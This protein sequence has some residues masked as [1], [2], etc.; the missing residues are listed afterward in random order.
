MRRE[1]TGNWRA[2]RRRVSGRGFRYHPQVGRA[3]E[4]RLRGRRLSHSNRH[5]GGEPMAKQGFKVMDSDM[6]IMEP[7]DLWQRY[8]DPEFRDQAPVGLTSVNF[9][10]LRTVF[11]GRTPVANPNRINES[12]HHFER[13]QEVYRDHGTRGWTADCQLEA[14]DTEGIDVAVLF[15]TR[16]LSV[17]TLPNLDPRLAAAIAR[18]Y[19]DWMFDFCR[20]DPKRLI[21]AGMLSVHHLK[22]PIQEARRG[23]EE[24]G[25]PAVFLPSNI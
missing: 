18:A 17:L 16:G 1:R 24:L 9:R 8:I 6:H 25:V 19:N 22:D 12:G 5:Q 14:M 20:L 23:K 21:G 15:P 7:P 11:P 2:S 10:E 4:A 3:V 13:L